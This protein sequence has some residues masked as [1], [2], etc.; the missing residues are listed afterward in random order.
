MT[1]LFLVLTLL[2]VP[3]IALAGAPTD[4]VYTS[5]DIGGLMLNGRFDLAQ[6]F[7]TEVV[8][9]FELLGTPDEHKRLIVYET[10]HWIDR[11]EVA[12]ETLAW[13]DHYLGPVTSAP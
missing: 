6:I 10:D 7:E 9:M 12:K 4:G 13:F 8:P 11:K 5:A 3:T 2:L 1:R